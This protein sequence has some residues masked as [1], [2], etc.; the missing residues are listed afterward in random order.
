MDG[1]RIALSFDVTA[2]GPSSSTISATLLPLPRELPLLSRFFDFASTS[3]R[4]PP[5][6]ALPSDSIVASVLWLALLDKRSGAGFRRTAEAGGEPGGDEIAEGKDSGAGGP[7]RLLLIEE[8]EASEERVEDVG[9]RR[10]GDM[11]GEDEE[12]SFGVAAFEPVGDLLLAAGNLNDSSAGAWTVDP[13]AAEGDPAPFCF[14]APNDATGML[15]GDGGVNSRAGSTALPLETIRLVDFRGDPCSSSAF[16]GTAPVLAAKRDAVAIFDPG[17]PA[18]PT[19]LLSRLRGEPV[20]VVDSAP[21]PLLLPPLMLSLPNLNG[22]LGLPAAWPD[23]L[24]DAPLDDLLREGRRV[25]PTSPV[26]STLDADLA[27]VARGP[28]APD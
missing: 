1:K 13:K 25:R 23:V 7:E 17:A 28:L 20:G 6:S 16:L 5:P 3:S 15:A 12:V 24:E 26:D 4:A 22:G 21:E 10:L 19:V 9:N 14:G 2:P 11:V 8:G 18:E 27:R